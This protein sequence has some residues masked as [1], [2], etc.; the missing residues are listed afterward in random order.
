M[1]SLC[2]GA[3]LLPCVAAL[4]LSLPLLLLLLL[5][6][7]YPPP[8]DI[9]NLVIGTFTVGCGVYLGMFAVATAALP[10]NLALLGSAFY[11]TE[12]QIVCALSASSCIGTDAQLALFTYLFALFAV[13]ALPAAS[14]YTSPLHNS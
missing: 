1:W 13:C 2:S 3:P 14:G 7:T 12:L 8:P 6:S 4:R 11:I 9:W 10:W 5:P